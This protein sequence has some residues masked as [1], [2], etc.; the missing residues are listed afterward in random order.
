[1]KKFFRILILT[2]FTIFFSA[3]AFTVCADD[4][5][6]KEEEYIMGDISTLPTDFELEVTVST[7]SGRHEN[8]I[9]I[10]DRICT[11]RVTRNES[12]EPSSFYDIFFFEDDKFSRMFKGRSLPFVMRRNYRGIKDG[13]YGFTFV[14]R[15]NAGKRGKGSVRI[16]VRH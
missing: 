11:F 13:D 12:E 7:D 14:A 8:G 16:Q 9:P 1:M 6:S 3:D 10:I 2:A 15:D 4:R 5:S